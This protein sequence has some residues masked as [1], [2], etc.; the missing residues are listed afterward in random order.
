MQL[1]G[2]PLAS[3]TFLAPVAELCRGHGERV[4]FGSGPGLAKTAAPG[5]PGGLSGAGEEEKSGYSSV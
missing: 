3:L 5:A 2:F 4:H 1:K